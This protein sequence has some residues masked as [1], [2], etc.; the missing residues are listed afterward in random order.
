MKYFCITLK[1][2]TA[3]KEAC[4]KRFDEAGIHVEFFDGVDGR[5][6]G[7]EASIP[8]MVDQPNWKPGDGPMYFM[9][10]GH[11]GCQLSHMFLWNTLRHIED[12]EFV[13]FE[14]DV[15]LCDKFQET[16]DK[17]RADAPKDWSVL[18]LGHCCLPTQHRII[19][20]G[21]VETNYP[22]LCTHA[23]CVKK[24]ALE[25]LFRTNMV[26]W[27]P[28]DIQIR[29]RSLPNLRFYSMVPPLVDQLSIRGDNTPEGFASLTA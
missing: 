7:L 16:F 3:R 1:G 22:P 10:P 21:L 14:D 17:L 18:F 15:I 25:H 11:I 8:Y 23:Y 4:Q 5:K 12:D 6:M 20:P 13:I 2:S 9:A 28:I 27:G 26:S 24:P 19:T 29:A